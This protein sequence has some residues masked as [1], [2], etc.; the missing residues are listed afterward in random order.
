M[1]E[2]TRISDLLRRLEWP[3]QR[4]ADFLR[5]RQPSIARLVAGQEESGPVS[6]L[7]DQ[8]AE[9]LASGRIAAR[10]SLEAAQAAI[11]PQVVE[12]PER[13]AAQ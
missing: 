10:C 3:Q 13:E 11:L 7:L 5:L 8:L 4:M 12:T 6:L 9:A 1:D 2:P